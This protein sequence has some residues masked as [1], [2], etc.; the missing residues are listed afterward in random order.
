MTL[1]AN[2][3]SW[4]KLASLPGTLRE[5]STVA[6]SADKIA[7]I[8][9]VIAGGGTTDALQIYDIKNNSWSQGAKLPVVMNHPNGAV[10]DGKLFLLGGFTTSRQTWVA[11]ATAGLYDPL[12]NSW[13]SLKGLPQADA[14]GA[15]AM[16][17]Y[18]RTIYVAGGKMGSNTA[19]VTT[20][21]A[22][23]VD[24]MDW[25]TLP[26]AAANMP[27]PRDHV[28]GAV[29]GDKFYVLGGRDTSITNVKGDV[30]ILDLK[31]LNTGWKT[32]PA[33]MPTPRGGLAV[34]A[35]NT[36]IYTFGGEGNQASSTGVFP[37]VEVYDTET[38]SWATLPNMQTPRHGTYGA[39]VSGVVYVP[40]GA[41]ASGSGDSNILESFTP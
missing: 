17:V 13:S 4:T 38:D 29:V 9:G 36:K 20:V 37:Q 25:I 15:S 2:A 3:N 1:V 26:S 5:H 39:V 35:V 30:Y 8:G 31:N 6:L 27:G 28:G 7:T 24:T 40:G 18:N 33:K 34:G 21:S 23:N 10:V 19:S 41:I 11:T 22:F 32:S 16:G 14:R 12:K